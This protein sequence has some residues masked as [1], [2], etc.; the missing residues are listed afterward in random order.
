VEK[1]KAS[2][3]FEMYDNFTQEELDANRR[4]EFSERQR[5]LVQQMIGRAETYVK[6]A[7][8]LVIAGIVFSAINFRF[9]NPAPQN[10]D[11]GILWWGNII[12]VALLCVGLPLLLTVLA[13]YQARLY[14]ESVRVAVIEGSVKRTIMR[15]ARFPIY[16]VYIGERGF[17]VYHRLWERFENGANYRVYYVPNSHLILSFERRND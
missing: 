4:G 2:S 7:A 17:T 11:E 9:F 13:V 5:G 1:R 14:R 12:L 6:I 3:S 10:V 15:G 8:A 16:R